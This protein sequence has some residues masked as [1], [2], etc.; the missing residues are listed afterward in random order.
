MKDPAMKSFSSIPSIPKK[1]KL[2][3]LNLR[4]KLTLANILITFLAVTG[5]GGYVYLRTQQANTF[6]AS[7]LT[8]SVHLKAG[9]TLSTVSNEQ[10]AL[11]NGF[12]STVKNDIT[13][14]GNT[15]ETLLENETSLKTGAY[16]DAATALTRNESNSWDNADSEVASIFIPAASELTPDLIGELNTLKLTEPVVS[17]LLEANPDIIAVYFGGSFKET[18]YYPNINL[19]GIVPPDFDVTKRPWFIAAAAG[20]N[21]EHK[22]VWS[23][24]YEDAAMHGLVITASVPIYGENNRFR[25]VAAM[26]IQLNRISE[27]I[28]EIKIGQTGYGFL[29]D[30]EKRLIA[31][32][33]AGYSDFGFTPE[34]IPLGEILDT[35]NTPALS[36]DM[37]G[38]L[39]RVAK[40]ESNLTSMSI[41]GK[42]HFAIY[43]PVP[44]I[45]YGLVILV[46]TDE[47]LA[48]ATVAQ[49]EIQ[50]ITQNTLTVSLILIAFVLLLVAL[51]T[52]GFGNILT[53]P[54]K[55]LTET[56]AQI[57]GGNLEAQAEI[58]TG[59]EI[60]ILG[61]SLNT[62]TATLKGFIQSLEQRVAE[63]TSELQSTLSKEARRSRQF[64][65]ITRVAQAAA[66]EQSTTAL[67]PEVCRVISEQFGFYHVGIFLNDPNNQYAVL[68]ASNSPGG[69][70]MMQRHHQLRIGEQG[71]VGYVTATGEPRVALDVGTD[72][73]F[74]DNPDLPQTRSEMALPL[75]LGDR[76]I[77]SL[78]VQSTEPNAFTSEDTNV[79]ST[80]AY[81]VSLA[82]QNVRLFDQTKKSLS[83][84]EALYRQYL[85]DAWGRLPDAEKLTGFRYSVSGVQAVDDRASLIDGGNGEEPVVEGLPLDR[86]NFIE[87]P[88]VLRGE[89]LGKFKVE[90]P[91]G[92][93]Q[94]TPEQMDMIQAVAERVALSAENA[95]LFDEVARRAQRERMVSEIT[96]KIRGSNEPEQ[97]IRIAM[98]ELRRALDVSRVEVIPQKKS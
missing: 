61:K 60:G 70:R 1:L 76:T 2:P 47:L 73:V 59:D 95:R 44:E 23:D 49:R 75:K 28:S 80:L 56:A 87:V 53:A 39:D 24:P 86:R 20:Q 13:S 22:I 31:F 26:D 19:A 97:M 94:I 36:D 8:Q 77:G 69:K 65:A 55:V 45:G 40:G 35:S 4:G 68:S 57:T 54:L 7:Q 89:I 96:T 91:D 78:D 52:F 16:W 90:T 98:E 51:A 83:E 15:I 93:A 42:A 30:G 79:L 72:A 62:M 43:Q 63:R 84:A 58:K 41:N 85:R 71:I 32:P 81:Q 37:S 27:I 18:I 5:M 82:I 88:I 3:Q 21:P 67:L 50:R 17:P 48:E 11:L 33:V 34:T 9:D 92:T 14:V 64:E 25:G 74:F 66:E 12:F 38:L 6:L 10:T 29:I 46:P